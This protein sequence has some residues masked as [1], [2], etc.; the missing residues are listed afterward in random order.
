[1]TQ[2][3]TIEL[4]Q[5]PLDMPTQGR[6]AASYARKS[7]RDGE[8]IAAQHDINRR[9]AARDGYVIPDYLCFSDDDTSG[10]TTS[11]K[12]L[13]RL[14][15]I[16]ESGNAPFEAVYVRNR[17]RLGRWDDPGM[18]DYLRI[19]FKRHGVQLRFSEGPNPDYSR[20]MTPQVMAESIFDRIETIDASTERAE[21][22]R[23]ITTGIRKRI[24]E[25]FWPGTTAP[26]A[27]E[28]WLADL[29]TKALIQRVED[30]VTVRRRE[31]GYKL[32][33]RK[34][35]GSYRAVQ[36]IFEWV[37]LELLGSAEIVKRLEEQG[38]PPPVH[39]RLRSRCPERHDLRW[40][41][42]AVNHI[43]RNRIYC[44]Q[45]VWPANSP[46]ETAKLPEDND[47]N[48]DTPILY[49]N[50]MPDPPV[51]VERF[52]AVQEILRAGRRRSTPKTR[53]IR[54]LLSGIVR[55]IHCEAPWFGHRGTYYRHAL[56]RNRHE[57]EHC[58][59]RNRYVRIEAIDSA[60]LD[61]I[62]PYLESDSFVEDVERQIDA[63][64]GYLDGADAERDLEN[65]RKSLEDVNRQIHRV[66]RDK[67]GTENQRL[68]V[69]YN[70]VL[71]EL[72]AEA[73]RLEHQIQTIKAKRAA[74]A[75]ARQRPAELVNAARN[76][77]TVFRQLPIDK[78]KAVLSDLVA[79]VRYD[80]DQ[81]HAAVQ[82]RLR[83]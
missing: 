57:G 28:R 21:I 72:E 10:A 25:G 82:L 9:V 46:I 4:Q 19:H 18:H 20:G 5:S 6:L 81:R 69:H 68:I 11:R 75:K 53:A 66:I 77:I 27:T 79:A 58:P 64:F 3:T 60:V 34:D 74:I 1:M 7:N 31:C 29:K 78:R 80:P 13:D 8:G 14:I 15:E 36:L 52:E 22:K 26:Y 56:P 47:L 63:L 17:K 61:Q 71:K 83:P 38:F 55:C 39:L 43:L 59:H 23:R 35:D 24:V 32:V 33:W 44:G 42:A 73:V 65:L 30:G 37:H 41:T 67:A 62:L 48:D 54:P 49:P 12:G 45:L 51:S 40:T 50:F 70:H 16:I 2:D 76:V